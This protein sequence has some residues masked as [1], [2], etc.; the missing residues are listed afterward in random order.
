MQTGVWPIIQANIWSNSLSERDILDGHPFLSPS[1]VLRDSASAKLSTAIAKKTLSRMSDHKIKEL[2][3][4]PFEMK[5][6]I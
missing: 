3:F 4:I 2:L 6:Q 5:D 1:S